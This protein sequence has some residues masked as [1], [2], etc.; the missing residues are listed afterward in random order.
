MS[1]HPAGSATKSD[2]QGDAGSELITCYLPICQQAS[3]SDKRG[4]ANQ[5]LEEGVSS[6]AARRQEELRWMALQRKE[7]HSHSSR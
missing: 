1:V 3:E 7:T 2:N 5:R 6:V 4:D